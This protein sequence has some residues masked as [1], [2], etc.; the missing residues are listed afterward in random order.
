MKKLLFSLVLLGLGTSGMQ[1]QRMTD[2][3]DRGLVAMPAA[4]GGGNFISWKIF[5]PNVFVDP[6]PRP[7]VMNSLIHVICSKVPDD[8]LLIFIQFIFR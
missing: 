7:I 4:S 6:H 1:A 2:K 3:L 8:I 5:H